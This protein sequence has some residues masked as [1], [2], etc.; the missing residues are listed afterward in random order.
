MKHCFVMGVDGGNTKTHYVLADREG[1][2][3]NF[4]EAGSSSHERLKGYDGMKWEL[5]YQISRLLD[6]YGIKP[7]DLGFSVL[8]LAGADVQKQYEEISKRL[9][10]I[11]LVNFSLY[12][13]AY[14]G[15]KAGCKKGYGICSINGTGTSCTGV[16]RYGRRLQ[17]G[18][19][20]SITGDDAGGGYLWRTAIRI[21]YESIYK[22]GEPTIMKDMFFDILQ[23]TDED[24][25]LDAVYEQILAGRTDRKLLSKLVFMAAN[26][27]DQAALKLLQHVGREMAKAV[28]GVSRRLDFPEDEELEVIL[29]GSVHVKGENP[30][31]LDTFRDEVLKNINR[32]VEFQILQ[33]PPVA[34]AVIWALEEINGAVD[35]TERSKILNH[36]KKFL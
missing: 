33:M 26:E 17:V 8:G 27:G 23:I 12:N 18:G 6:D 29:A 24:S 36:L 19:C 13:D 11:G 22:C 31:M 5:S 9:Q 30:V 10:E 25:F 16:D 32:R 35:N 28:V 14:L 4:I 3:V 21:V 34:G 2:I 1:N 7:E 20:G 15:I